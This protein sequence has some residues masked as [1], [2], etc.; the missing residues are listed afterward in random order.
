MEN[1]MSSDKILKINQ[2]IQSLKKE[3]KEIE[4]KSFQNLAALLSRFELSKWDHNTLI[5]AFL[6]LKESSENEK[7]TWNKSG[8]KFLKNKQNAISKR[9]N[10][11]AE[12]I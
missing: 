10:I 11:S 8:E 9:K 2:K 4:K 1:K 7:E 12:N 3:K 5:G 6:F